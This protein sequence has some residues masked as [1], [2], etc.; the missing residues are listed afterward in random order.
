MEALPPGS[1]IGKYRVVRTIAAG[2][3]GVVYEARHPLLENRLAIKTIRAELLGRD[4][5]AERFRNEAVTASRLRDDRIPQIYD[6]DRVGDHTQYIVMEYL[7]G[8]DL[9]SRLARGALDLGYA[10]RI[11]FEVLDVLARVH[12]LGIVHRDIK[13]S[14]IF[15]ARSTMLG[16][17]PK[18][19]DFG[20]AHLAHERD[21]DGTRLVGTP[22]YMAPEQVV[23][24]GEL[25]PWTD[26]FAAA[27]VLFEL[28]T[29]RRRPWPGRT[30]GEYHR[31]LAHGVPAQPLGTV[32]P[33]VPPGL[34]DALGRALRIDPRDRIPS[35]EAFAAAVEPYAME[36]A[37][38]HELRRS[39]TVQPRQVSAVAETSAPDPDADPSL[40][41]LAT[42]DGAALTLQS[43]Q[44][45]SR[46][47]T[48]ASQSEVRAGEVG[49]RRLAAIRSKLASFPLR[50]A[51]TLATAPGPN[52]TR[53]RPGE[54]RHVT[55]VHLALRLHEAGDSEL[56]DDEI[57]QLTGQLLDVFV[58]D[59]E[60][61]DAHV[62]RESDDALLAVFGYERVRETDPERA[63]TA[64][65][66]AGQQRN[67]TNV[68]LSEV[69]C[70]ITVAVGVHSGFVSR[71]EGARGQIR[72]DTVAVARRLSQH[73]P[74][75][76]VLVSSDTRDLLEERFATREIGRVQARGR[77][78]AIDA[79]EVVGTSATVAWNRRGSLPAAPFFGRND[80][81]SRLEQVYA[82]ACG[83]GESTPTAIL[84]TGGA[85]VGKTRLV[86]ELLE[87]IGRS[88]SRRTAIVR[89]QPM[90]TAPYALWAGILRGLLD[91]PGS[92]ALPTGDIDDA[93][94]NLCEALLPSRAARLRIQ[95]PVVEWMLGRDEAD[96]AR[97]HSP[98]A[99]DDRIRLT[100]ALCVEARA[101]LSAAAHGGRP[102]IIALEN[103]HRADAA[104]LAAVPRV[105]RSVEVECPPVVVVTGRQASA[106][107]WEDQLRIVS[108]LV[109]PLSGAEVRCLADA[110]ASG[111]ALSPAAADF[112]ERRAGGNPLFVEEL[113]AA[114]DEQSLGQATE[115]QLTR[116]QAPRSLYGLI[117]SRVDRLAPPLRQTLRVASVVGLEVE[118]A[119]FERVV[120]AVD[121]GESTTE[122]PAT[123]HLEALAQAG[124]LV[125]TADGF[126]FR[127]APTHAAVY[128]T[129]L[130][131]NRR[132][133]HRLT[134]Q[135]IERDAERGERQIGRL[136]FHYSRT[137]DVERTVHYARR[138]GR[139][140][141]AVAAYE[142]AVDALLMAVAQQDRLEETTELAATETLLELAV[143][144]LWR[145]RLGDSA[146]RIDQ[147][148]RRVDALVDPSGLRLVGE[149]HM[150]RTEV[151]KLRSQQAAAVEHL[152]LA[153][154]AFAQA[155]L[156]V[157][158][159]KARCWR[160]YLLVGTGAEAEG[161]ALATTGWAEL[162]DSG[163]LGAVCRAGHDLGNV[164][165]DLGRYEA[166]LPV[167][168]RAVEAGD[169]LRTQ[170]NTTESIWGSVAGRSGRAMTYARLG[171][172]DEAV[173][174]Q[175][176][177]VDLAVRDGNRVGE[178]VV[179]YH[180][181]THL[182]ERG[183]LEE[184][185]Q[186][187]SAALEGAKAVGMVARAVKALGVL[188]RVHAARG[189]DTAADA[190]RADARRLATEAG[191]PG[192][193]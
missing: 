112:V 101:R 174:H 38:F 179:R 53:L 162:K 16:E 185:G 142:D 106:L 22:L 157:E 56:A 77:A 55:V 153:E 68:V 11:V 158:A 1:F 147:G 5:L 4:D 175:R 69:G 75:N 45:A 27:L 85:G 187:A 58:T 66:A 192:P 111:G 6:I 98:A 49:A 183:D 103:A 134:A 71:G 76:G 26:V 94:E 89:A 133:I 115:Q 167:F 50:G 136:L 154:H 127:N 19:L 141:L 131:E 37:V 63:V 44:P 140:A 120:D 161:L 193:G 62:T 88:A 128:G 107:R 30:V 137:D 100:L 138:V 42:D 61:R 105:L 108:V 113:V 67:A 47:P 18:L 122:R 24:G 79:F 46:P 84:L 109:G 178:A 95:R 156:P 87:R 170:G 129:V 144:L 124:V 180:L 15:L 72:G 159:A 57:E 119:V 163:D 36:R 3:M 173:T 93:F 189:D 123:T 190:C 64:A 184:A 135:A 80:V 54:R 182:L 59:L 29:G 176:E 23:S 20:I 52:N 146:A 33:G 114:L 97:A 60:E 155:G 110:L 74:V 90:S 34:S 31:D 96:L 164:L 151:C 150:T 8:E 10:A 82:E 168:D 116:L 2:G 118:R 39:A 70:A 21:G 40:G 171:R 165:R 172:L 125:E 104:S 13:P 139:R 35:A 12:R 92:D 148:L 65:L 83:P 51:T 132:T 166:S 25:G 102:M 99:L 126:G 32:S 91:A 121:L 191:L 143:A 17:V 117:L 9:E 28:V 145:G 186:V 160:G 73:A 78:R 48:R 43:E 149:L 177:A 188:A 181:A 7:E 14:N 81:L 169:A 130:T 86:T 41:L 152:E